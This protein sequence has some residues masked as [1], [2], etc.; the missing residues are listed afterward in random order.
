MRAKYALMLLG[1][2]F[3]TS[4]ISDETTLGDGVI[5]VIKIDKA[6]IQEEYNIEKNEVLVI[7]PVVK[8]EGLERELTYTWE[9]DQKAYSQNKELNYTG[10]RLGSFKC[11]L[12][13]E[14]EDGKDFYPFTIN[15]VTPYEQGMT[16]VSVD[17][18]GKS[19][20]S[21]M[22]TNRMDGEEETFVKGDCFEINNPD[23]VFPGNVSDVVH[24]D[25]SLILSCKG[26]GTMSD[27][28]AMV[29]LNDKTLVME[30]KITT[31]EYPA[32]KPIFMAIP[33]NGSVGVSYPIL[34]ENGKVYEFS[35]TEGAL[36][37]AVK[38]QYTYALKS[39]V[40]SGGSSSE[41]SLLFWDK[42][43]GAL[44]IIY[45]GRGPY[46][47]SRKYNAA[48][49]DLMA[50]D[51]EN[52]YFKGYDFV[53][54]CIP[55]RLPNSDKEPQLVVITK[56]KNNECQKTFLYAP[57][58][59][60][61]RADDEVAKLQERKPITTASIK[62]HKLTTESPIIGSLEHQL[63]MFA[64]GNTVYRWNYMDNERIEKANA[65][66][67]V[68]SDNAIITSMELSLDHQQLYVAYYEPEEKGLN[69]YVS[70]IHPKTGELLREHKNVG[71]RPVKLIYK[72]K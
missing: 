15:V 36:T 12:I 65:D 44:A 28:G 8:Q 5:S 37:P 69:G 34:C 30:N 33:A 22:Q 68:G 72:K 63:I 13:V 56:N 46:Y 29:Y 19:M 31:L 47:C 2:F 18:Q 21:F 45:N 39:A 52:N 70:V 3:L 38:L 60:L 43:I 32:F 62:S 64:D 10:N 25:G 7:N 35:T 51:G 59:W 48:R 57:T 61:K 41:F 42:E 4:C 50:N 1:I 53:T 49:Y 55:K 17:E 26:N 16:M 6:S 14:N 20:L 67:K 58:L 71:Y 11:R 40:Y 23:E 9:I 27:P 66:I 24:C 54:M